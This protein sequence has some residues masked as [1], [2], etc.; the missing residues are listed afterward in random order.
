MAE[1]PGM[2][3]RAVSVAVSVDEG[4]GNERTRRV[5]HVPI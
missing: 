3:D 4:D 5:E 1:T 2:G